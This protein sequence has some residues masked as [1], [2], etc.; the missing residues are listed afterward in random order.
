MTPSAIIEAVRRRGAVVYRTGDSLR[1]RP[2]SAVPP[3]LIE[4][5]R[6][7]KA[8]LL[9]EIP[10]YD[11]IY[12][13]LT[14]TFGTAEDLAALVWFTSRNGETVVAEIFAAERCCEK[15]VSAGAPESEF[16]RAVE[17]FVALFRGV[18]EHYHAAV[19]GGA[20]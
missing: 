18:R 5:L 20:T 13:T 7:H 3:D 15:L 17:A 11:D 12:R 14:N 19:L 9:R 16:R 8:A 2:A 1:V 10:D 4:A 6:V